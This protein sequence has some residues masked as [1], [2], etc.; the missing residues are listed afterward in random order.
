MSLNVRNK[1]LIDFLPT[2]KTLG[3]V[4]TVHQQIFILIEHLKPIEPFE[5]PKPFTSPHIIH[6]ILL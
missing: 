5:H 6:P 1:S 4:E 3:Y 2:V